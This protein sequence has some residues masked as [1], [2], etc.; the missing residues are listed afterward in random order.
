MNDTHDDRQDVKKHH[1]TEAAT[2]TMHQIW[3]EFVDSPWQFAGD[4]E[5]KHF[6]QMCDEWPC[7]TV[8]D[9]AAFEEEFS[10]YSLSAFLASH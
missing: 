10:T 9:E 5:A 1:P 8:A 2:M 6:E 3:R 4:A 7:D